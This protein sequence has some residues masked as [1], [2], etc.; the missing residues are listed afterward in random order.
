MTSKPKLGTVIPVFIGATLAALGAAAATTMP[1]AFVVMLAL[2]VG[3]SVLAACPA[4]GFLGTWLLLWAVQIVAGAIRRGA[5]TA[6]TVDG[7]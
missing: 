5:T 1:S 4:L 2:G 3:H 7:K 6:V